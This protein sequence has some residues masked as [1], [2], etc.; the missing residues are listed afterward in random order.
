MRYS[1]KCMQ[2]HMAIYIPRTLVLFD[3]VPS[4]ESIF[5][6]F[7]SSEASPSHMS[8]PKARKIF[9]EFLPE[10]PL[11]AISPPCDM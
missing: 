9:S 10:H 6:S 3:S 7:L 5:V 8:I 11:T 1:T 2:N 4:T